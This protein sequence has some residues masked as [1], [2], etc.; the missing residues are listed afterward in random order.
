[1]VRNPAGTD[2]C[3]IPVSG[4]Y[5]KVEWT[6]YLQ[7]QELT[8]RDIYQAGNP[9]AVSQEERDRGVVTC[10]SGSNV[11]SPAAAYRLRT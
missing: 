3:Q 8:M 6:M 9:L 4:F 7:W 2:H 10:S 11:P 1:V 5:L